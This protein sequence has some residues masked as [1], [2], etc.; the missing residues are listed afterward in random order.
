MVDALHDAGR[1]PCAVEVIG[2]Q[3]PFAWADLEDSFA[4][5]PGRSPF[6]SKPGSHLLFGVAPCPRSLGGG[7]PV[8]DGFTIR[9]LDGVLVFDAGWSFQQ[10]LVLGVCELVGDRERAGLELG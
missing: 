3:A 10:R 5:V 8:A 4:G 2:E 7:E 9:L 6:T 1:D